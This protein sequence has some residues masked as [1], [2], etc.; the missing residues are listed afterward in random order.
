MAEIPKELSTFHVPEHLEHFHR[1]I[2]EAQYGLKVGVLIFSTLNDRVL[3]IKRSG[4]VSN[5]NSWECPGRTVEQSD[6]SI[7][8]VAVRECRERTQLRISAFLD[9]MQDMW[10]EESQKVH[11]FIFLVN[12]Y[13]N[14]RPEQ[15]LR[16]VV[17][18]PA[19]HQQFQWAT[20]ME[21]ERMG[22]ALFFPKNLK[23][24]ILDAFSFLGTPGCLRGRSSA[25]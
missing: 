12:V 2:F 19:E 23:G 13:D 20:L 5:R 16:T 25:V 18:N 10:L 21:I 3:L 22:E 15:L 6:K 14:K 7:V 9:V 1:P 17:L 8:H 24:I 4:R 11:T